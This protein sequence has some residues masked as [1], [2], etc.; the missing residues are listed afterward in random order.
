M[1]S[2]GPD[3]VGTGLGQIGPTALGDTLT[4]MGEFVFV[5]YL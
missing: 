2:L 1:W 3:L 5:C 4:G